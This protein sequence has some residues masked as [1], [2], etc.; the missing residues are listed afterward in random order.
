MGDGRWEMGDGECD[1]RSDQRKRLNRK[2]A[3]IA[4]GREAVGL[5]LSGL[6]KRKSLFIHHSAFITLHSR[7]RQEEIWDGGWEMVDELP[8]EA[9]S[10]RI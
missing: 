3:K 9:S 2:V 1:V 8:R 5:D 4:K 10:F 7:H 6:Q